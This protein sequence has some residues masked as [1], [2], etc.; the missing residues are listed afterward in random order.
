MTIER[1]MRLVK[2]EGNEKTY[3]PVRSYEEDLLDWIKGN[4]TLSV[5]PL[6]D[7]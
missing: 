7:R 1:E 3:V 6:H 2:S 4:V 5:K